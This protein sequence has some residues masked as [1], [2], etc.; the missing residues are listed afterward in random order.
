MSLA[1]K[2]IEKPRTILFW[3]RILIYYG[4]L[5]LPRLHPALAVYSDFPSTWGLFLLIPLMAVL[6]FYRPG[7][8]LKRRWFWPALLLI[9]SVILM[10]WDSTSLGFYLLAIWA[11][12]STTLAFHRYM[13]E[14]LY[15]EPLYF[16]WVLIKLIGFSHSS[17]SME[18]LSRN[19]AGILVILLALG[20][21]LYL[22]GI[23]LLSQKQL[24]WSFPWRE[25]V[26]LIL[27]TLP[28]AFL[29]F[30]L[31]PRSLHEDLLRRDR[32][33]Q[34]E[35]QIKEQNW[36]DGMALDDEGNIPG[37]S[38]ENG[39]SEEGEGNKL[40]SVTEEEWARGKNGLTGGPPKQYMV[41]VVES[42]Q[43]LA[44]MAEG[45]H[46]V[47]DP[48]LGFQQDHDF[49]LNQISS[50]R[51]LETWKNGD[52]PQDLRRFNLSLHVYSTLSYPFIPY[53][54]YTL[55]PTV[56]DNR[57]APLSYS[58]R[59]LSY[60]SRLTPGGGTPMS[61]PLPEQDK[62]DLSPY[63]QV[64]LPE[65]Y[66]LNYQRYLEEVVDPD[67]PPAQRIR[68]ILDSFQNCQYQIGFSDDMTTETLQRFLFDRKEGDCSEFS[69]TAALLGR[70]AGIPTRV[71]TGYILSRDLQTPAHIQGLQEL[72]LQHPRLSEADLNQLYLIT[73]AH[74]HSWT[75]FYISPYGWVD[76]E[77]TSTAIPPAPG[78]DLNQADVVIPQ[79]YEQ[80]EDEFLVN[81]PWGLLGKLVLYFLALLLLFRF[82]IRRW[83]LLRLMRLSGRNDETGL[84]A[85][86]SLV[87][88]RYN[89]R[90]KEPKDS[91]LTPVELAEVWPSFKSFADLYTPTLLNPQLS[92]ERFRENME[93]LRFE[94]R[95]LM[96]DPGFDR[97][98]RGWFSLREVK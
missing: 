16:V 85:L 92:E 8:T 56:R 26:L 48:I 5:L 17:N 62:K 20:F 47:L 73:T 29:L 66:L 61:L 54:P 42:P 64:N 63:L 70:I 22:L 60:P 58:Y 50:Q 39:T 15:P 2:R 59:S 72:R 18:E 69:H 21:F 3:C 31:S 7:K 74:R 43:G 38:G 24:R 96:K 9:L 44:Y 53:Y 49:Y 23:S 33:E 13:K 12:L 28:L 65:K 91:S 94:Y 95:A 45:Y 68:S 37:N 32:L 36:S 88:N 82:L 93:Q 25:G 41:M 75:Q 84:K 98:I 83:Y 87:I 14:F 19:I 90:E 10:G 89:G 79:L 51:F 30:I 71:V 27:I 34:R 57:Y 80:Q 86:Y 52:P 11:W 35:P 78:G 76:Y 77:T 40:L 1:E 46:S 67:N 6:A 81:L 55:E 4:F 97:L